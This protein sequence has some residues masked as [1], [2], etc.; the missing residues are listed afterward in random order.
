MS[1]PADPTRPDACRALENEHIV[2]FYERQ[3]DL[4]DRVADFLAEGLRRGGPALIVATEAHTRAIGAAL[5]GKQIDLPAAIQS[6][7]LTLLDARDVLASVT[8]AGMPD[9]AGFADRLGGAVTAAINSAPHTGL[10]IYDEMIDV[11]WQTAN[12]AA[13]VRL[14]DLWN[15]M[16]DSRR[17][18]LFSALA[19]RRDAEQARSEALAA[20]EEA[21]SA[22]ART[23]QSREEQLR[24][25]VHAIRT[26][27]NVILG[28]AQMAEL[29]TEPAIVDRALGAIRNNA[30]QL[31]RLLDGLDMS[32]P[33]A[34]PFDMSRGT[35]R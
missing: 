13:A 9:A 25:L 18:S 30:Q 8:T 21:E 15:D 27:L 6:G 24:A 14:E 23:V 10:R 32:G 34:I 33:D 17:F 3:D 5:E 22:A 16:A 31:A 35:A 26:P 1:M 19:G 12:A 2:H 28:W 4:A 7:R 20:L 29:K 11:L